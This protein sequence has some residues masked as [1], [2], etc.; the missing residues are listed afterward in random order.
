MN[1]RHLDHGV[2]GD[3]VDAFAFSHSV[4][5]ALPYSLIATGP[6]GLIL[7]G[8]RS[9]RFS[10]TSGCSS[11]KHVPSRRIRFT[12]SKCLGASR[13]VAMGSC[14]AGR[15]PMLEGARPFGGLVRSSPQKD[16]VSQRRRGNRAAQGLI[17]RTGLRP[18]GELF[19]RNEQP[20][21]GMR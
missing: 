2:F 5:E 16:A 18:C 19:S 3:A 13:N 6:D 15:S 20:T 1:A 8:A 14:W 21:E 10:R 4:L 9:R 11:L 7:R 17:H 12:S